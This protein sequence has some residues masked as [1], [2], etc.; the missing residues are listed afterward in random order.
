MNNLAV[1]SIKNNLLKGYC[2]NSNAKCVL[3][4]HGASY[5]PVTNLS[6]IQCRFQERDAPYTVETTLCF[7]FYL[8]NF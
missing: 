1:E 2:R 6:Q 5:Y 7:Y 3:N 8:T 4:K